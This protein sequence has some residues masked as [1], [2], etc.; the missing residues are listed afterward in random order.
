MNCKQVVILIERLLDNRLDN[1]LELEV[2][3]HLK[4]CEKC[5]AIM[6]EKR[7][8]YSYLNAQSAYTPVNR[9]TT[10]DIMEKINKF[11][12]GE[13]ED[14]KPSRESNGMFFRKLGYSMVLAAVVMIFSF[15]LPAGRQNVF[16]TQFRAETKNHIEK[17]FNI[18]DTFG[19]IDNKIR[20]FFNSINIDFK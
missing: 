6:L 8:F 18:S 16:D 13:R 4:A 2:K 12:Q 15:F 9:I 5:N 3:E 20:S 10:E 17:Q 1:S 14:R 7:E 11:Q 19:R